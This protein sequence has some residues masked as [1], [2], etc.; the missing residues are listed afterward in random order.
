MYDFASL[1]NQLGNVG[2]FKTMPA[3]D[4]KTIVAAGAVRRFASGAI[5]F[6]EGEPSAG[7]FVLMQGQVHLVKLGP[8][9][10]ESI[11]AIIEPVIMFNEV[12]ALDGGANLMTARATQ[13]CITWNVSYENFRA[14]IQKYPQTGLG[15]LRVLAMRYR[16]LVSQYEDLSFRSVVSRTAKLLLDLSHDGRQPIDRRVHSNQEMAARISTVPEAL[17]RS[18][19]LFK[20][21]QQIR[22]SRAQIL[23]REPD[24]LAQLAQIGPHLFRG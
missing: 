9:G 14:L 1:A 18:L 16:A 22:S 4:L 13:D 7:M 19:K 15:L 17:S 24:T 3:D 20:D 21:N 8:Q 23:I 12:S 2:H 6:V 10:H 11:L 5:I